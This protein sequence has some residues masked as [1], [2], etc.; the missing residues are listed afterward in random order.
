MSDIYYEEFKSGLHENGYLCVHTY[1][2]NG[3]LTICID[4]FQNDAM[5]LS[6]EEWK[7]L[8]DKIDKIIEDYE[9]SK[10]T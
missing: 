10:G 8:R 4:G 7:H 5:E 1:G 3:E 6:I 9:S 2:D